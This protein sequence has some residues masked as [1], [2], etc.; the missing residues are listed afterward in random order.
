VVVVDRLLIPAVL[1]EMLT[2]T[3]RADRCSAVLLPS[4]R[5]LPWLVRRL[6]GVRPN[7]SGHS[8][9]CRPYCLLGLAHLLSVHSAD[10]RSVGDGCLDLAEP[11]HHGRPCGDRLL[12]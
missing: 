10:L 4:C 11:A 6:C 1:L 2:R 3:Y 8:Q 12:C 5:L 9:T 7:Q